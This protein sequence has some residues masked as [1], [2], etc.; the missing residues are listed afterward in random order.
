MMQP[1]LPLPSLI[2]DIGGTNA[3]FALLGDDGTLSETLTFPLAEGSDFVAAVAERVIPAFGTRPRSAMLA[4]AGIIEGESVKITNGNWNIEPRRLKEMVGLEE[5]VLINDFEALALALPAFTDD[6]LVPIGGGSFAPD[7]AKLVIGP[8]TG[9]GI[10]ALIP[11]GD[12]WL[13]VATEGGHM[14]F[15]PAHP[16]EFEIWPFL[17]PTGARVQVETVLSG[18]GLENLYRAITTVEGVTAPPLKAADVVARAGAG[19]GAASEA[20]DIF[21][22]CL[23]RLAGDMT[24]LYLSRGGVFVAGGIPP[25]MVD[26]FT[27]GIFRSAFV[28]KAPFHDVLDAI[29]TA[30]VMHK[31]PAFLG[32]AELIRDPSRFAI[33]LSKRHWR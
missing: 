11:A 3:R 13:P 14:D 27:N 29:A 26:R 30:L 9:L 28:D 7:E 2:A 22:G 33:D 15:G 10:A 31:A 18:P 25:R 16:R 23:G 1:L 6:D 32:A 12:R 5:V 24:L 8:G 21:A 19:D 4:L 20:L 17:S